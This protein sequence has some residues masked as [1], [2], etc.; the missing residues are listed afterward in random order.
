VQ[1]TVRLGVGEVGLPLTIWPLGGSPHQ[2]VWTNLAPL[3][4]G[5]FVW[6]PPLSVGCPAL[7][8]GGATRVIWRAS[9]DKPGG[10]EAL[11]ESRWGLAGL[12]SPVLTKWLRLRPPGLRARAPRLP[13]H[14]VGSGAVSQPTSATRPTPLGTG[15]GP[16]GETFAVRGR[17]L[18]SPPMTQASPAGALTVRGSERRNYEW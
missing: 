6:A 9:P 16:C 12:C 13:A 17:P 15:A 14:A 2:T 8:Q 11:G 4:G 7:T 5:A 18:D 1:P 10:R 3:S